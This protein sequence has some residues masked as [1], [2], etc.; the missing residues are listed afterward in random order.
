M[1]NK[2]KSL[3]T[4]NK[5]FFG[6]IAFVIFPITITAFLGE[7]S[8]KLLSNGFKNKKKLKIIVDLLQHIFL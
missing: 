6:I 2:F 8:I 4:L 3:N 7:L 1:W 5:I